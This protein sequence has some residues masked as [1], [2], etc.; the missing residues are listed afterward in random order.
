[1]AKVFHK[2][3]LALLKLYIEF[4]DVLYETQEL[5]AIQETQTLQ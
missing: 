3:P 5:Q 2:E 1:M 4:K